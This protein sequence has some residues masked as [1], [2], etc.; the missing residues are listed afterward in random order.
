MAA[1]TSAWKGYNGNR[2]TLH[3]WMQTGIYPLDMMD[4]PIQQVALYSNSQY[5][6]WPFTLELIPERKKRLS[7]FGV[8]L[9]V[10]ISQGTVIYFH[11]AFLVVKMSF[12][13]VGE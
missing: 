1:V 2:H 7:K 13:I 12:D 9:S 4:E 5:S 10:G 11:A 8:R 3:A 6:T